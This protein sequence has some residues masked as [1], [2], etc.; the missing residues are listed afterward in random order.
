MHSPKTKQI[1]NSDIKSNDLNR[2]R[3]KVEHG[4]NTWHYLDDD[5]EVKNWPQSI[6]E[7]YWTGLPFESKTFERPRTAFEAAR[8]GFEFYKQLQ[9]SDGHWA[10][11][12]GGQL[13][14]L[15]G[16]IITMYITHIPIPEAWRI[17]IIRYMANK[18]NPVDGGWGLHIEHHSTVFGTALNYVM[19]RIL[20]LDPDH[21]IMRIHINYL[22]KFC[23]LIGGA[24]GAPSWGK[25]WLACLNVYDWEGLNPIPPEPWLLPHFVP[26]HPS[27]FWTHTRAVYLPMGYIYGLRLSAEVT[28]LIEQLRQE[29]YVQPFDTINWSRARNNIADVDL[30]APHSKLLK[31]CNFAIQE[32]YELIKYDD[33]NTE[34]INLAAEGPDSEAFKLSK[35]K[36]ID[37]LLVPEGMV[38]GGMDG[39]QVWDTAHT[40]VAINEAG[41]ADDPSNHQSMIKALEF[42]DDAQIKKNPKDPERCYRLKAVLNL[43]KKLSYTPD[44]I[45]KERLYQA[46]DI[47][48][49]RQNFDGGYAT[50]ECTKGSKI[51]EWLN[52]V[53]IFENI[54]IEYSYPECTSCV[55]TAL[56]TFQKCYPDYRADEIKQV[57]KKAITYLHNVQDENGGWYGS[58]GICYTHAAMFVIQCLEIFGET[59]ENRYHIYSLNA[60]INLASWKINYST[61]IILS[62]SE[63]IK[64]GFDFL[65]SK[66][67]DDGGWGESYKT[68]EEMTYIHH[69]NSQVVHT[70]WAVLALMAGKYP[71]E[72][73]I[74]RGIQLIASR[75]L[76]TGEWKQEAAV[77]GT[78]NKTCAVMYPNYKYIFNIWAL[79]KYAKI[80]DNPIFSWRKEKK[81]KTLSM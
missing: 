47:L 1:I 31:F 40:A 9:T 52:P 72:E 28:P 68:C 7:K 46:V 21:P 38:M 44:L 32:S 62:I 13:F 14:L 42:L 61:K 51:L 27:H 6:I 11:I 48:L 76:P 41:L 26:I 73:P 8:N 17:E 12:I 54:M 49:S 3:L 50:Y 80:Y 34:Y 69:E 33:E 56:N 5:E 24:I 22:Q 65:I 20:G 57:F 64:K 74:R 35:E 77:E 25:F 36:L 37:Y 81:A 18:A 19:L 10:G 39:T 67:K 71:N 78:F 58:W 4:R 70:A 23:D 29:L 63:V 43:Q 60:L 53:E 30:Y 16:L 55:I 79:G 59:Y 45:S 2:W 75:Q 66:Q 15:P